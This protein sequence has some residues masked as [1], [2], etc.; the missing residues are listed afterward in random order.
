MEEDKYSSFTEEEK[1]DLRSEKIKSM[2]SVFSMMIITIGCLAIS[3]YAF[4]Y[5]D[6]NSINVNVGVSNGIQI[7][8]DAKTWKTSI[9]NNDINNQYI[10]IDCLE[11]M[12]LIMHIKVI[13]INYL[14]N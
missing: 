13:K 4:F 5:E 10:K 8:V 6:K 1:E 11:I 3:S 2:I 9:N 7:S 14:I 12:I